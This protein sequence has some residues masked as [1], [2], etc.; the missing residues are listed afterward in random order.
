MA[1]WEI[2]SEHYHAVLTEQFPSLLNHRILYQE[3]P[4]TS[5]KTQQVGRSLGSGAVVVLPTWSPHWPLLTSAKYAI[6]GIQSSNPGLTLTS[7]VRPLSKPLWVCSSAV[8]QNN[9]PCMLTGSSYGHNGGPTAVW[10]PA[11]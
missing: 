5:H 3:H 4:L 2:C 11:R 10:G 9:K 6:N 1:F 8:S 7:Y